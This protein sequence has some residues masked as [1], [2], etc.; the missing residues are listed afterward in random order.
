[1]KDQAQENDVYSGNGKEI[2]RDEKTQISSRNKDQWSEGEAHEEPIRNMVVQ[3]KIW[4]VLKDPKPSNRHRDRR[5]TIHKPRRVEPNSSISFTDGTID[6]VDN[7]TVLALRCQIH[8]LKRELK[9]RMKIPWKPKHSQRKES[10]NKLYV[11]KSSNPQ[12]NVSSSNSERSGSSD[13]RKCPVKGLAKGSRGN[14]SKTPG[15]TKHVNRMQGGKNMIWKALYQISNSPF[16]R[17]S[18]KHSYQEKLHH[19]IMW[20][21]TGERIP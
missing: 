19:L 20:C 1:M 7:D 5:K 13:G 4:T 8:D 18:N 21:T 17:T 9:K 16:P 2:L 15:Q 3:S 14:W 10:R 12:N 6:V 11:S